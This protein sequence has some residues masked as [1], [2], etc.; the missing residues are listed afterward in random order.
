[1][2]DA[3]WQ[4]KLIRVIDDFVDDPAALRKE[5]LRLAYAE[6]PSQI[7][8]DALGPIARYSSVPSQTQEYF[9]QRLQQHLPGDIDHINVEYRYVHAGTVKR[10]VCHADGCDYAGVVHLTLPE[11]CQGGTW[12]FRHRPTGHICCDRTLP[13]QHDYTDSKLWER[14]YEAPMRFNRLAFY[15][16]ELFHAIATPHFGDRVENARLAMTFFVRL[17]EPLRVTSSGAQQEIAVGSKRY[18]LHM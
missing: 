16:G 12:F 7:K 10:Q 6:P 1:M 5:A 3:A 14:Y 13:M 15:P 8:Q 18:R 4:E 11:H 17:K 9:V 2:V